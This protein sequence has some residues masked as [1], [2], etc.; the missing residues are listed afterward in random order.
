M[1]YGE[2]SFDASPCHSSRT[3][4]SSSQSLRNSQNSDTVAVGKMDTHNTILSGLGEVVEQIRSYLKQ[5]YSEMLTQ[6]YVSEEDDPSLRGAVLQDFSEMPSETAR[7]H[8]QV[9]NV[10]KDFLVHSM[11]ELRYYAV[12]L[13]FA[14]TP[15]VA[16][17][18]T[19]RAQLRF[20][21]DSYEGSMFGLQ[22]AEG[23]PLVGRCLTM[24]GVWISLIGLG[25]SLATWLCTLW[26][27][28]ITAWILIKVLTPL[29]VCCMVASSIYS[30]PPEDFGMPSQLRDISW[31]VNYVFAGAAASIVIVL[32]GR[33]TRNPVFKLAALPGI[34]C[35]AFNFAFRNAFAALV[36]G[37][38]LQKAVFVA[39]V[40][41][42]VWEFISLMPARF[43]ARAIR[44][45]HPSTSFV[46]V[47]GYTFIK[48]YIGRSIAALIRDPSWVIVLSFVN[49]LMEV[50]LRVS[51]KKRDASMYRCIFS[52]C[53]PPET[54]A[55]DLLEF[56]RNRRLRAQNSMVESI[57]E[58][59]AIWNGVAMVILFDVSLDSRSP[60]SAWKAVRTGAMQTAFEFLADYVSLVLLRLNG[61]RVL[62]MARGRRWYWSAALGFPAMAVSSFGINNLLSRT[63]CCSP[64]FQDATF[65]ACQRM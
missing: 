23:M 50:F 34:L 55:A 12:P 53:L 54:N 42:L 56:D 41:P 29:L 6:R 39:V 4:R 45:N 13:V 57:G 35:I 26:S 28:R 47:S 22:H 19:I 15:T 32:A 31:K 7:R 61:I 21:E 8:S 11:F 37:P 59:V 24:V 18:R 43:V 52:R 60:M 38:D 14:L 49:C 16:K 33:A 40:N 58:I 48:Q 17:S 3:G 63:L 62:D 25:G 1:S 46:I 27:V 9:L 44:H 51:L 30:F 65:A 64:G 5:S 36:A 20:V 2:V 10:T